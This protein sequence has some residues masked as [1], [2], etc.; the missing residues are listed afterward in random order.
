M[1]GLGTDSAAPPDP[2]SVFPPLAG[3]IHELSQQ[4]QPSPALSQKLE[5]LFAGWQTVGEKQA[6]YDERDCL[7]PSHSLMCDKLG[8]RTEDDVVIFDYSLDP[9]Y[10]SKASGSPLVEEGGPSPGHLSSDDDI[11]FQ[12][13]KNELIE[14]EKFNQIINPPKEL[15]LLQSRGPRL[16]IM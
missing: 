9:D 1:G 15:L 11:F 14:S 16:G 10:L 7:D 12:V 2:H 4:P 3:P 8:G 6:F 13:S 5:N